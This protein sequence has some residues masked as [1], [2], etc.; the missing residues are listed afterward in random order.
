MKNGTVSQGDSFLRIRID[1][2]SPV[3]V[4]AQI[5]EAISQ[6]GRIVCIIAV[7]KV[8]DRG[9]DECEFC[10]PTTLDRS[11]Q[12]RG[13]AFGEIDANSRFHCLDSLKA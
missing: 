9:L 1:K 13:R 11:C 2:T 7:K 4:Y 3:P 12:L 8:I 6:H 5:G 10:R